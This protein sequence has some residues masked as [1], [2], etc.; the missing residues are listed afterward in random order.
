PQTEEYYSALK[1]LKVP[2]VMLRFNGE[3]H[4]TGSKPTNFMRTQLYMMS[5]F[6]KHGGQP[7]AAAASS[8]N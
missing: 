6:Q 4:G 5:W 1:Y 3:Y 2:V 8:S 7:A